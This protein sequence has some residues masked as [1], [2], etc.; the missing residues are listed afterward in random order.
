MVIKTFGVDIKCCY[1]FLIWGCVEGGVWGELFDWLFDFLVSSLLRT[2]R[3]K[4]YID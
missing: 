3:K 4:T 1:W 2:A